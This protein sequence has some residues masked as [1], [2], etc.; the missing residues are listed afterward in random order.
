MTLKVER[1]DEKTGICALYDPVSGRR[2]SASCE[3]TEKTRKD[4]SENR[5]GGSIQTGTISFQ[6]TGIAVD[7]EVRRY[8]SE[9]PGT[10]YG[11]ALRALMHEGDEAEAK[12]H[13]EIG[14][15]TRAY[16]D[17]WNLDRDE[18]RRRVLQHDPKLAEF[19]NPLWGPVAM[20]NIIDIINAAVKDSDNGDRILAQADRGQAQ[21]A[22][23]DFLN[24]K[25]HEL[26][27]H[28][29]LGPGEPGFDATRYPTFFERALRKYPATA[30][31]YAGGP[32]TMA[33]VGEMLPWKIRE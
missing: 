10:S 22:A 13:A 26:M 18:A 2:F 21:K 30:E 28:E 8:Q 5:I 16:Q 9:H 20:G 7:R 29:P 31:V 14:R 4:K 27:R 17:H 25:T 24:E 32:L 11:E 1:F 33:A 23:G 3:P 19:E 12:A 15:R 6:E